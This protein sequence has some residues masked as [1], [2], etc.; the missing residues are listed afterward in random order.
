VTA[1][2]ETIKFR[3]CQKPPA[4]GSSPLKNLVIAAK[5]ALASS[6][7]SRMKPTLMTI[8]KE[9]TRS[10]AIAHKLEPVFAGSTF[11]IAL[12][13]ARNSVKTADAPTT[14]VTTPKT[15]ETIPLEG[16]WPLASIVS[17]ASLPLAPIKDCT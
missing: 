8:P 11:Q 12:S 1:R 4:I 15:L 7:T 2:K 16:F 13:A 9:N 17:I 10:R 3:T 6:E 5:P 14:S